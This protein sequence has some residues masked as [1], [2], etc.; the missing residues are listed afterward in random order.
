[1]FIECFLSAKCCMFYMQFL[2]CVLQQ[3][4]E[5]GTVIAPILQMAQL[6]HGEVKR[7]AQVHTA[8]KRQS[9]DLSPD[10]I[11]PR[12]RALPI[13]LTLQPGLPSFCS[14]QRLGRLRLFGVSGL[15]GES[16]E[17]RHA[18]LDKL[19][20]GKLFLQ[21]KEEFNRN[22]LEWL[23]HGESH[24]EMPC[25]SAWAGRVFR[26]VLEGRASGRVRSVFTPRSLKGEQG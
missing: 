16:R 17:P 24:L 10:N 18:F 21:R 8:S 11:L 7:L 4:C 15:L 22:F 12:I 6:R 23:W 14:G 1:M 13:H 2:L 19:V 26:I 20:I 3:T 9:W 25:C 5:G